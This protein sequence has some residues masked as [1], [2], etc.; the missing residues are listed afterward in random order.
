MPISVP[1]FDLA[2]CT[3]GSLLTTNCVQQ[4]GTTFKLDTLGDRLM[5]RL[6]HLN[7]RGTQHYLVTHSVNN[8]AAVAA[9]W[10]EFRVQGPGT[11]NLSPYQ[12][13]QT[14]E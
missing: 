4:P 13:G 6:A 5:Y 12:S 1:A 2:L 7:E 8:A 11:T 9:R 14:P 10:Y 3:S